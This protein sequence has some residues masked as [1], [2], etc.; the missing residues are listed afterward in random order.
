MTTSAP[1]P[2]CTKSGLAILP[3]R[4]AVVPDNFSAP[5]SSFE[6]EQV[7]GVSVPGYKY[8][9]R[10]LRQGFLYVFSEKN[11]LGNNKWQVYSVSEDG[12][13]HLQADAASA[14]YLDKSETCSRCGANS[15]SKDFIVIEQ[16]KKCPSAW[17]AF[18]E[19]KWS[20]DT[21]R[22]Y[23][24]DKGMRSARMQQITPAEWIKSPKANSYTKIV[25][26]ESNLDLV[27]EYSGKQTN[28]PLVFVELSTRDGAY[29]KNVLK[30]SYSVFP[31]YMRNGSATN[32]VKP[33]KMLFDKMSA[34]SSLDGE[35][36][37]PMIVGLWDAIGIARD[38]NGR[39]ND[40][41]GN[42]VRYQDERMLEIDASNTLANMEEI[43]RSRAAYVVDR[44]VAGRAEF[45]SQTVDERTEYFI[46]KRL[47]SGEQG[48]LREHRPLYESYKAGEITWDAYV[49]ARTDIIE[50][51]VKPE[52]M[53]WPVSLWLSVEE[54]IAVIE[55][56]FR[57]NDAQR[58]QNTS[59]TWERMRVAKL[60]QATSEAL[61]T[62]LEDYKPLLEN[63]GALNVFDRNY[64]AFRLDVTSEVEARVPSLINWLEAPLFIAT[65]DDYDGRL[66]E[67]G[68]IF[69]DVV[70]TC[71]YGMGCSASGR[72]KIEGWVKEAKASKTNLVWRGLLL[73]QED[74]IDEID[75]KLQYAMRDA[76]PLSSG[77][78]ALLANI[79]ALQRTAD[80][81]KK[82]QTAFNA[83]EKA[84]AD[85]ASGGT[86]AFGTVLR[87]STALG[88]D[89]L[90][91]KTG[92]FI[93]RSL[94]TFTS[95]IDGVGEKFVQHLLCLRAGVDVQDS[96]NLIRAQARAGGAARAQALRDIRRMRTRVAAGAPPI[97]VEELREAWGKFKAKGDSGA[98]RSVRD[99]RLALVVGLL[100]GM[101]LAKLAAESKGDARS[102]AVV[103]AS[104][105]GVVGA[106]ADIAS[107][108][109]K[110]I[111]GN[112]AWTFQRLKLLGGTLA[113]LGAFVGGIVAFV[114]A[115][116]KWKKEDPLMFSLYM[117]KGLASL[118]SAFSTIGTTL[119]YAAPLIE[120]LTGRQAAAGA[121][122][123]IGARAAAVVGARILMLSVGL[124]ITL[125]LVAIEVVIWAFT[126]TP[127]QEWCKRNAFGM[128]RFGSSSY[129]TAKEQEEALALALEQMK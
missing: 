77:L 2:V 38:L 72:S 118:L 126:P 87:Q 55:D 75:S 99:I 4:Y 89:K 21:R 116:Q 19:H 52:N 49:S 78:D 111:Y 59:A 123:V 65:L 22:R 14:K 37:Y 17:L 71:M 102:Y 28:D 95:M 109:A 79:K 93:Y 81:F 45:A 103:T 36:V 61:D 24:S 106:V 68:V 20:E 119:S 82:A 84:T 70:G 113:G 101:N 29:D 100:E 54:R 74:V 33:H 112:D 27:T 11:Y 86:F 85:A 127:L 12:R 34:A 10:V 48:I 122:R 60:P 30:A 5:A 46:E 8:I 42:A 58:R 104:A 6:C 69:E 129:K 76:T 66:V 83:I 124:W 114:D 15:P 56:N 35:H 91:V 67:D 96:V 115:G 125:I 121:A 97:E 43:F 18:S 98:A 64:A 105:L 39:L 32:L 80:A 3:S 53:N 128:L 88:M 50:K 41:L 51:H 9:A 94:P 117:L 107:V 62:W 57:M 23:Q 110:S 31:W 1:C 90:L 26:I 120:R 25:A 108:P 16:P 7:L 47:S 44:D 73:N 13:L 63:G 92:E 40:V